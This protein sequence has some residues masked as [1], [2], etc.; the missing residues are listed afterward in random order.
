MRAADNPFT[1]QKVQRI[2]YRPAGVT[3][4]ALLAR[5]ASQRYRAAI[6]GPHGR[7]KTTLLEDL[8]PRLE[9]LG[10]R[11]RSVMLHTGGRRLS[12]EQRE[13]LLGDLT[14]ADILCVDG[15]EQLGRGAWLALR[16]RSREAGGLVITSHRPGLLPT[17][18]DCETTPELL[19]GIVREL[20]GREVEGIETLFLRHGGNVR[21][22][23]RE[24]YDVW[25]LTPGPSPASGRGV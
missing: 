8:A 15:A 9:A 21:A 16:F 20:A 13:V 12:R 4:E 24:M 5:L 7:G 1:V 23:L 6:V 2:R 11:I 14:P 17:L 22:A 19:E 3:W 10:F 25:A 18:L